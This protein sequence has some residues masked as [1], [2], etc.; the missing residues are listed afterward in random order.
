MNIMLLLPAL[1]N[2]NHPQIDIMVSDFMKTPYFK[3]L[4][5]A[6]EALDTTVLYKSF[7]HGI[8]H[9]ER[10]LVLGA[11]IAWKQAL[12]S[13]DTKLLLLACSYH[14]VGR[15]HDGRDDEH[16]RRSA[17]ML[18]TARFTQLLDSLT[19]L[20]QKILFAMI[21]S[22]SLNDQR[23]GFVGHEYRIS[24]ESLS[25]Y[26][27]LASCLKDADNLDRV[28]LRDLDLTHL[29]HRQSVDLFPFAETLFH[30]YK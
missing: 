28:R 30:F 10:V 17:D 1:S 27:E 18:K 13:E 12:D 7:F 20:E 5:K 6:Y 15:I 16:G 9:I 25:R 3:Y 29:R 14:D 8:T 4:S 26:L 11:M 23:M 24:D 21:T 22:H 19:D 2:S